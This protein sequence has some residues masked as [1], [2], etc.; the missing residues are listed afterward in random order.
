MMESIAKNE[1]HRGAVDRD[2]RF[3]ELKGHE[4]G[5]V[6]WRVQR[7]VNPVAIYA[8][9][10]KTRVRRWWAIAIIAALSVLSW[11]VL[12]LLAIEAFSV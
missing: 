2:Q 10:E 12:M 5:S 3:A 11:V 6:H 4:H 8:H 7:D 1:E 9:Y